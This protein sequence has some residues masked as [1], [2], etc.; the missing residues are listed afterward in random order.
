MRP[1]EEGERPPIVKVAAAVALLMAISMPAPYV[2]GAEVV[3]GTG[4]A[5]VLPM[6]LL[7]L[8]ASVGMW[9]VKYWAVLGFQAYLALL[10]ITFSLALIKASSLPAALLVLAFITAA[11]TLFWLLVRSMARIQIGRQPRKQG[12]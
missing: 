5:T 8:V 7:L 6:S 4:I 2:L 3:K 9:R 11:G 12:T 1:L 10:M